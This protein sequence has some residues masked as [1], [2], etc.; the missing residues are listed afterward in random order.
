[1]DSAPPYD[2][3]GRPGLTRMQYDPRSPVNLAVHCQNLPE[4][5]QRV[6]RLLDRCGTKP[7]NTMV[8]PDREGSLI[9]SPRRM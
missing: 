7:N 8:A 9:R 6:L 3:P 1:M 5:F 4:A 2:A